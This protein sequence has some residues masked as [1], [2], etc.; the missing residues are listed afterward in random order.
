MDGVV[1]FKYVCA[2][3]CT[4]P[5]GVV[6]RTMCELIPTSLLSSLLKLDESFLAKS[7]RSRILVLGCT[8]NFEQA[9]WCSSLVSGLW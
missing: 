7:F 9:G 3:S 2:A 4:V 5:A 1:R 6:L 8:P